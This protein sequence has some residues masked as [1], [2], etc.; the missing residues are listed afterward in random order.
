MG[1]GD[2]G[3]YMGAYQV[4]GMMGRLDLTGDDVTQTG[5]GQLVKTV[6]AGT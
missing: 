4:A 2:F 6:C 1:I 3:E 5:D